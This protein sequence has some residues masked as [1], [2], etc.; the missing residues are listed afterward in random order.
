MKIL[1]YRILIHHDTPSTRLTTDEFEIHNDSTDPL[2]FIPF[3]ADRYRHALVARDGAGNELVVLPNWFPP[4]V[5]PA[6]PGGHLPQMVIQ[7]EPG[8]ELKGGE[9]M[10]VKLEYRDVYGRRT[11]WWRAFNTPDHPTEV[12]LIQA[13]PLRPTSLS[14]LPQIWNSN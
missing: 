9:S 12:R 4:Q 2:T 3:S 8:T 11:P 5:G 7:L 10:I 6:P 13:T 14:S 1:R